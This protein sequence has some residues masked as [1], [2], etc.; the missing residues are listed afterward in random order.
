VR[1]RL[2]DTEFGELKKGYE[3][4]G[5]MDF[6]EG[7]THAIIEGNKQRIEQGTLLDSSI[8]QGMFAFNADMMMDHIVK[9]FDNAKKLYG[10]TLLRIATGE[11]S[12]SLK[13]NI[14][15]PEFQR[16]LKNKLKQKERE[17]KDA[18]L[19]D[20]EGNISNKG[21]D[22]ASLV[23]Y[24]QELDNLKSKGLGDKK[25]KHKMIYGDKGNIR[26]FRKHDRYRDIS[27][28]SSVRAAIRHGHSEIASED[29]RVHERDSKGKIF[30]VYA[31]DSSGSMKGKKIE[32]CKK[33]GV[34]LAYKAINENDSVGLI[35]F[36]SDIKDVVYPTNDFSQFL[37]KITNIRAQKQTDIAS[38]IDRA[39][40]L[41]PRDDVTKHL[42]LL[43][44]AVPT[45][46][47]DPN[48]NTLNLV[49][50]ARNLGIT[51]SVVGIDL[52]DEG[53]SLAK[54]IVEVGSGRL[55]IVSDLNNVDSI[56]LQD[57]YSL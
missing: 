48:K 24:S 19:L 52:N 22:L 7:L 14:S 44:D 20:K 37:R 45:V 23:M 40:Q 47:D 18:D 13:R 42:I 2:P 25:S 27:I 54:K 5:S 17:L 32:V 53:T 38:T 55:Y 30:L 11:D 50:K 21:L 57:Y 43:T 31:L 3:N 6:D 15:F 4:S 51:V 41:F 12:G 39:I 33:A 1:L 35:V 34:A 46:G 56:V 49:E 28:K 8:N 9:N 10:E 16:H 29:F 36:G 26:N